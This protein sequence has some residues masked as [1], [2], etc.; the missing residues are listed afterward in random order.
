[1]SLEAVDELVKKRPEL[2]TT[3]SQGHFFYGYTNGAKQGEKIKVFLLRSFW[4]QHCLTGIAQE[5][6]QPGPVISVR[7]D[8]YPFWSSEGNWLIYN[9]ESQVASTSKH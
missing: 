3:V 1:M 7:K 5:S 8:P 2:E 4:G 9:L 6:L